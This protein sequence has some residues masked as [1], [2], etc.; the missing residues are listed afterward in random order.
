M[1]RCPP[2][3]RRAPACPRPALHADPDVEV[4]RIRAHA[5]RL[6]AGVGC[7]RCRRGAGGRARRTPLDRGPGRCAGGRPRTD[8]DDP[9]SAF[10]LSGGARV[11]GVEA[12]VRSTARRPARRRCVVTCVGR[13]SV[14]GSARVHERR[15]VGAPG[16]AELRVDLAAAGRDRPRRV[17][18]RQSRR[19][20]AARRRPIHPSDHR[21][22]AGW[23]R[24]V[25]GPRHRPRP[26]RRGHRLRPRGR[27]D[28][29]HPVHVGELRRRRQSRRS[30]RS[31]QRLRRR[32]YGRALPVRGWWRADDAGR[33]DA[34]TAR[35]QRLGRLPQAGAGRG[36]R[37]REASTR[38]R[39][40]PAG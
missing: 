29:V 11:G 1:D 10:G 22:R 24:H 30:G 23:P 36:S 5:R 35:L 15:C 18:S 25:A 8:R 38:T 14:D 13:H 7:H 21:R 27:A 31:V 16:R 28:A 19:S 2:A 26:A 33:A 12:A 9:R 34:G 17:R 4:A 6:R 40:R 32:R 39:T 3:A 20:G 37:L